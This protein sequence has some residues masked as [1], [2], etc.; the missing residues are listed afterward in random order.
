FGIERV[1]GSAK[2]VNTRWLYSTYM[3][4]AKASGYPEA[5]AKVWTEAEREKQK[6]AKQLIGKSVNILAKGNHE[7]SDDIIYVVQDGG[8]SEKFLFGKDGLENIVENSI[9]IPEMTY[10]KIAEP[11]R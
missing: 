4:F 8:S 10:E 7:S 3:E 9:E 2:V 5:V 6:N 1:V 11:I